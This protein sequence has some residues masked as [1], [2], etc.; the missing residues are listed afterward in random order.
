M[1]Y[2]KT[3]VISAVSSLAE[4]YGDSVYY[5][6]PYD[7]NEIKC[8]LI[9]ASEE[10]IPENVIN[11]RMKIISQRQTENLKSLCELIIGEN[12]IGRMVKCRIQ[13]GGLHGT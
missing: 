10:K 11:E 2:G 9:Q 12:N 3:C 1:K 4:I 8:R 7:L 6:N 13:L 5:C